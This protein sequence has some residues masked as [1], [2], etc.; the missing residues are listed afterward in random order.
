MILGIS[1]QNLA[2][3]VPDSLLAVVTL[4]KARSLKPRKP[5]TPKVRPETSADRAEAGSCSSKAKKETAESD[6]LS[7]TSSEVMNEETS[8]EVRA[9]GDRTK[10]PKIVEGGSQES[11]RGKKKARK[12][13]VSKAKQEAQIRIEVERKRR[14]QRKDD[15]LQKGTDSAKEKSQNAKDGKDVVVVIDDGEVDIV[16]EDANEVDE[17]EDEELF[18]VKTL[19][20]M[21][22]AEDGAL[23]VSFIRFRLVISLIFSAGGGVC[24]RR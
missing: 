4:S 24:K 9:H 19:L 13:N 1:L 18:E 16:V 10:S 17:D 8:H 20:D 12:P 5:R 7:R 14:E 23:F 22:I 3:N 21:R 2:R 6:A 15:R 11:A